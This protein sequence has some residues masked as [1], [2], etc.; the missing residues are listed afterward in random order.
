MRN[1]LKINQ[2]NVNVE[3]ISSA[4]SPNPIK[5]NSTVIP[6]WLSIVCKKVFTN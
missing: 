4:L 3:F 5:C 1:K 6:P 2:F